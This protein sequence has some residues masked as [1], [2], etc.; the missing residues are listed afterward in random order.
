VD[1][2]PQTLF[3]DPP[4]SHL[5]TT[6]TVALN[7]QQLKMTNLNCCKNCMRIH[8]TLVIKIFVVWFCTAQN[9]ARV[10]SQK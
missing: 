6:L 3:F 4:L 8:G 1:Q 7:L 10:E 5:I 9:E 2:Q